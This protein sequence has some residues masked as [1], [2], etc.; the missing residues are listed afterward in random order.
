MYPNRCFFTAVSV[1][2]GE[3]SFFFFLF[4]QA[5][6]N[7]CDS[8]RM[9]FA[10]NSCIFHWAV[11]HPIAFF[12]VWSLT[13]RFEPFT[14]KLWLP[15]RRQFF[16]H[17]YACATK[18]N[19]YEV[20]MVCRECLRRAWSGQWFFSQYCIGSL[21]GETCCSVIEGKLQLK[22][23]SAAYINKDDSIKEFSIQPYP[24]SFHIDDM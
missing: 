16:I 11:H 14:E 20:H 22:H 8:F 18:C 1:I 13:R 10:Q 7:L 15:S 12:Q 3:F 23:A 6:S 4:R 17:M 21:W 5:S 24:I 9:V 19:H 2:G